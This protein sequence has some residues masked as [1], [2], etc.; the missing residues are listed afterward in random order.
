MTADPTLLQTSDRYGVPGL[1]SPFPLRE[2][3]PPMLQEDP[4]VERFL[5]GLDEVIAPVISVLDSFDAYL[6]PRIAPLDMVRYMGTWVLASMD[7][8][9]TEDKLRRDVSTAAQRAKWAG[10]ARALHDRLVPH[11]VLALSI[12]EYGRV[13]TSDKPTDPDSWKE[14]PNEAIV[15]KVKT[16]DRSDAELTRISRIAREV[17]P[18]HVAITV[19]AGS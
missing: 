19:I 6:D 2:Q 4:F 10:T 11:E 13:E 17:I 1:L 8:L 14:I 9:W 15:L 16:T 18:A 5:D 3:V 12:K 7:D